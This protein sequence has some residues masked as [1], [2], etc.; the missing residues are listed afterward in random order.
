[1]SRIGDIKAQLAYEP[2]DSRN[3]TA[4][5]LIFTHW[6]RSRSSAFTWA[7]LISVLKTRSLGE[8]TLAQEFHEKLI[9]GEIQ[10][11]S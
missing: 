5:I 9:N 3:N 10:F 1:M 2:T 4:F 8:Q 6:Q 11:Q 7:T